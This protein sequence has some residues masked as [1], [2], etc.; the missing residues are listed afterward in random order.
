MSMNKTLTI[1]T[2]TH[3]DH[4]AAEERPRILELAQE[5]FE[6]WQRTPRTFTPFPPLILT[7]TSPKAYACQLRGPT[8]GDQAV[9]NENA[10][11]FVRG[12]RPYA[13][14]MTT[15][16][17]TTTH[18]VTMVIGPHDGQ[19]HVLYTVYP[20][21]AA[22]R[23]PGDPSIATWEELVASRDFWAKHALSQG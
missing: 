18:L 14:R 6:A 11:Y 2:D 20:G 23:E 17:P 10:F 22:P 1:H 16:G 9:P 4:F 8:V 3:L 15:L 13:S 19:P 7:F 21:P 12:G 5:H